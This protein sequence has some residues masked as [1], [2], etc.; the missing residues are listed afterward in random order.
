MLFN[1]K[2]ILNIKRIYFTQSIKYFWAETLFRTPRVIKMWILCFMANK[3]IAYFIRGWRSWV[4]WYAYC[5]SVICIIKYRTL[6][7]RML[8]GDRKYMFYLI[9]CNP[10]HSYLPCMQ[11]PGPFKSIAGRMFCHLSLQFLDGKAI[12]YIILEQQELVPY[13]SKALLCVLR[14]W[15][16]LFTCFTWH[17]RVRVTI[18]NWGFNDWIHRKLP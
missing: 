6:L 13:W 17:S 9:L 7:L 3:T 1:C 16:H 2:K 11:L 10:F 15:M 4:V 8:K 12:L 14:L 18:T 5:G